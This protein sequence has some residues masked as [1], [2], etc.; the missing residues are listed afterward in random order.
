MARPAMDE[1]AQARRSQVSLTVYM[2][3]VAALV[4]FFV[5]G[6]AGS[7]FGLLVLLAWLLASI[8]AVVELLRHSGVGLTRIAA[9]ALAWGLGL[10]CL[11]V[12]FWQTWSGPPTG[13]DA[14]WHV[15]HAGFPV[16]RIARQVHD[17]LEDGVIMELHAAPLCEFGRNQDAMWWGINL[18]AF[19]IV[20]LGVQCVIPRAALRYSIALGIA[21]SVPAVVLALLFMRGTWPHVQQ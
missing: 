14:T 7:G 4:G 5:G 17:S 15:V 19:A 16:H 11:G 18:M 6:L 9:G 20:A 12:A 2:L 10:S 8:W 13:Y 21:C 3:A 1:R